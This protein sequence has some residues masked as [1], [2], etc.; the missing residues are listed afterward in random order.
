[1]KEQPYCDVCKDSGD[2]LYSSV[3][4]CRDCYDIM[5]VRAVNAERDLA[6]LSAELVE[7]RRQ[8]NRTAQ[9][10]YETEDELEKANARVEAMAWERLRK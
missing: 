2:S 10:L 3:E 6:L 5:V 1:M 4:V 8:T 7:S 9:T